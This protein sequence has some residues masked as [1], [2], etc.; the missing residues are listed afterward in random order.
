MLLLLCFEYDLGGNHVLVEHKL[1]ILCLHHLKRQRSDD[2][3]VHR[4]KKS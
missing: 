1:V 2:M 3:S 4:R